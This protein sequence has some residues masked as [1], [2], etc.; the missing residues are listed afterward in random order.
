MELESIFK[1]TI[2]RRKLFSAGDRLLLAVSGGVDSVVLCEL[3][4]RVGYSFVIA[5]CNFQLRGEESKRDEEFVRKLAGQ[6]SVEFVLARFDT[7]SYAA[8][9]KLSVQVAARDLRYNWFKQ[10]I[11]EKKAD[12]IL[13]AHHADDN[14]ETVLMNFFKGTGISGLRGIPEKNDRIVRP[15]LGIRKAQLLDFAKTTDLHWVEDS[16]NVSDKYSRNY[17]RNQLIPLVGQLYPQAEENILSN[18]SR[19]SEVEMI[20]QQAIEQFKK[21]LI[22]QKGSEFYIPILRLLQQNPLNTI[23]YELTK[24]FGFSAAQSKEIIKLFDSESG[25]MI[26]SATHRIIRHRKWLVISALA[27]GDNTIIVIDEYDKKIDTHKFSLTVETRN[28]DYTL[29]K[30]SSELAQLD[31]KYIKFPLILRKAKPGDYFY[32]LGM[33]KKKKLNRF[34]IDQKASKIEKENV[35]VIESGKRIA[36]VVGHRIDDRFKLGP[37]SQS[38]LVLIRQNK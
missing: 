38:T 7:E 11:D 18:I 9:N 32:P 33:K 15:L 4:K 12:W 21:K 6:Y 25:K 1:E 36:W 31:K 30:N 5:H 22:E 16:S 23:V 37:Q 8:E 34:L 20:Y 3:C 24:N 26:Q 14:I 27:P 29:V 10:F 13:T 17:F 28:G 35:W 2:E 19:F